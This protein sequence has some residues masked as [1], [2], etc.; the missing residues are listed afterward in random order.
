MLVFVFFSLVFFFFLFFI[1]RLFFFILHF[2]TIIFFLSRSRHFYSN[3][4]AILPLNV[5]QIL[6]A[7]CNINIYILKL[8]S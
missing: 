1:F 3:I 2:L 6:Y 4:I 5:P 7:V 8:F